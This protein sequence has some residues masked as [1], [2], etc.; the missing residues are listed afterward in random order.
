MTMEPEDKEHSLV[1]IPR[2]RIRQLEQSVVNRIAAGEIIIQPANA[3]KELLENSIDAKSTMIDVLVK[4]GGLKLLQITDNGSGIAKDD[5]GLLCE[6]FATSKLSTFDDLKSIATYGFR[7]E[8][9]ASISH[10]ARLSVVTK[11]SESPLAYKSFYSNGKLADQTFKVSDKAAPKPVAGKNGTQITVEDIFYNAPARLRAMKSK[12]D[13]Y[14]KI[15]DVVGRYAIH[16][17][18]GLSCKKF[19]E[20]YQTLSTRPNLPLK[21][22]IRTVFGSSVANEIIPFTMEES[23]NDKEYGLLSCSGAITGSNYVNKKKIQPVFFIN[24]RLIQCDPLKR[25]IA[26]VYNYFLPKGNQPFMYISLNLEPSNVDVNI[27]PTKKE[28]R[29]L[30]EDEIIGLISA[31]VHSILSNVDASRTFKTQSILTRQEKRTRENENDN[32]SLTVDTKLTAPPVAKK[33]RQENKLV[34]TDSKQPKLYS[35]LTSTKDDLPITLSQRTE[36][37]ELMIQEVEDNEAEEKDEITN[38]R[39]RIEVKLTSISQLK[40]QIAETVDKTLTETFNGCTYVGIIDELRRLCSFQYDVKLFIC[41]Y[42]AVLYEFYFQ[43]AISEFCN[44][45]ELVLLEPISLEE[46]L[47]PLYELGFEDKELIA[48]EQ[49]IQLIIDMK[50]MLE[51]YF[52]IKIDSDNRLTTLP[53]IMENISPQV[54]KLAHFVY[55]LGANVDYE[56][57]QECLEA[58]LR[59]ISLLYIPDAIPIDEHDLEKREL[60]NARRE[61]LD[62]QLEHVVFPLI[63]QKF[64]AP[65][66]LIPDVIQVAD[67]PGLY[68]VFERC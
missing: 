43:I 47:S 58:I 24:N 42:A 2:P 9:L 4:D 11:T 49:V 7:G 31:K 54:S 67:L 32:V 15:L 35:Y 64:L 33:Y 55:R 40:N 10:I 53:M 34:R 16:T 41:D 23:E 39:E 3:L 20:S 46:L 13:E 8:A 62:R 28:V 65:K 37:G 27:H 56:N 19:G 29:F 60:N 52:Q 48:K 45:G 18:V 51:E 17:D 57:E 63:Q 25:A 1:E 59:Q 30:Y 12:N 36:K 68:K 26:S 50:D 22:R 44:Y 66:E 61:D 38:D 5:L 21:E 6:R 14:I